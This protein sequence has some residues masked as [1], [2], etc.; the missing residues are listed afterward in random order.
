MGQPLWVTQCPLFPITRGEGT[1]SYGPIRTIQLEGPPPHRPAA[2]TA[3]QP[4]SLLGSQETPGWG[5]GPK[6]PPPS[7]PPQETPGWGVGPQPPLF[8][9]SGSPRQPAARLV[10]YRV[11]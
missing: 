8:S 6:A 5:V 4:A 10:G 2:P 1:G 3:R 7:S 9:S 11:D